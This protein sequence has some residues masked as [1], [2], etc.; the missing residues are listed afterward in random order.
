LL[1]RVGAAP[2]YIGAWLPA[3]LAFG[4]GGG[5][6]I[7]TLTSAAAASLPPARYGLG[8]AMINTTRQFGA[9]LGVA[10]L[11]AILGTPSAGTILDAFDHAWTF[12]L[13]MALASTVACLALGRTTS[14]L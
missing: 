5:L 14:H 11:I 1:A 3:S 8:S 13:A 6:T 4:I 10:I 2:A 12:C 9:V 7:P